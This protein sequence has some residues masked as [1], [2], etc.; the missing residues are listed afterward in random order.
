MDNI[1]VEAFDLLMRSLERQYAVDPRMFEIDGKKVIFRKD[2]KNAYSWVSIEPAGY[3]GTFYIHL[4]SL[5][6]VKCEKPGF[7]SFKSRTM[8]EN[9][10][11]IYED[12]AAKGIRDEVEDAI[13]AAV[14][15]AKDIIAERAL[16][17]D[18]GN[19]TGNSTP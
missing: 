3:S 7:W 6:L 2:P 8:W 17:G 14:P 11:K 19:E 4:D 13:V 12:F 15:A 1:S 18:H 10:S 9:A 5:S 16:V